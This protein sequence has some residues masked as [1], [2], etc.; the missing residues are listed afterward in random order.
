M[1]SCQPLVL[2]IFKGVTSENHINEGPPNEM[3]EVRKGKGKG[4]YR[5]GGKGGI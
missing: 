4:G 3:R 2:Q 5:K 1:T